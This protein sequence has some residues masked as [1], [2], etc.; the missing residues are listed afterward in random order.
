MSIDRTKLT[1]A[2]GG[3]AYNPGDLFHIPNEGGFGPRDRDYHVG[4]DYGAKAGTPIPAAS[5]GE[6]VYSGPAEGF[7]HAVIVNPSAKIVTPTTRFM[8][9]SI[10]K[11]HC[12]SVRGCPLG[13]RLGTWAWFTKERNRTVPT[14][15][16]GL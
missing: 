16:L 8:V 7:H 5:S 6:V 1:P 9:T 13:R 4:I 10:R 14:S 12:R 11:A 15:I 2:A 3:V